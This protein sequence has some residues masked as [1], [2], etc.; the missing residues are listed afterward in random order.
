M[1]FPI[2]NRARL[3]LFLVTG[4]KKAA[5]VR[6]ILEGQPAVEKYPAAGIRLTEGK[7]TWLLDEAAARLLT[8]R[9]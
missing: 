8:S 1:T 9:A 2:L 5:I 4:E 3:V 7:V 6:E